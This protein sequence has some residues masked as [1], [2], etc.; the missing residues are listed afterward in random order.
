MAEMSGG[1]RKCREIVGTPSMMNL[2]INS[3]APPLSKRRALSCKILDGVG[4]MFTSL[5]V[6]IFC[7]AC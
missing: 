4:N 6:F 3:S 5:Y 7:G 1:L 2:L